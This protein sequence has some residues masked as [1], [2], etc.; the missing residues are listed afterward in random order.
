MNW[1][2]KANARDGAIDLNLQ[3]FPPL[4]LMELKECVSLKG[5]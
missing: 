1:I 3:Q 5:G 4:T 2:P